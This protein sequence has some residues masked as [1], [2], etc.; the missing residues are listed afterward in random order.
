MYNFLGCAGLTSISIPA[1]VTSI[2]G[3]SFGLCT[4]LTGIAVEEGN[5]VYHS[6]GNCLIKTKQ[7]LLL[8]GCQNSI[9][10]DDGSVTA[11][12]DYAF[13]GCTGLTNIT[14]PAGAT[15]IGYKTFYG[16]TGLASITIPAGV[17]NIGIETFCSCDN[18]AAII[19][20]DGNPVYHSTGNCLIDTEKKA[21]LVGCKNSII[22]NDGSV[23]SIGL[24][25]FYCCT[26]LTSITIP[27]GV[28]SIGG[29]AFENC[30]GLTSIT[31]PA[32]VT[33]IEGGIAFSGCTKLKTIVYQG[34]VAQWHAIEKGPTWAQRTGDFTVACTDGILTKEQ[35]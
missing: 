11:I 2:G 15:H 32:S 13:H 18:L 26:G 5:P 3:D 17:T 28:T 8:A 22:P 20:E 25:A 33:N 29:G 9:I 1:S 10:P 30:T 23:T 31:I 27:A 14:I 34:T 19:V 12:A 4:G 16:C 21:L 24:H 6:A 35:S 7:K